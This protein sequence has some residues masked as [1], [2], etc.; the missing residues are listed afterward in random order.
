MEQFK[1]H[2]DVENLDL[3]NILKIIFIEEA[4]SSNK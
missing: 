3:A 4:E 2:L 1:K